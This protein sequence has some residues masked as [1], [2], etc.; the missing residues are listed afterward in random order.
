MTGW[1]KLHRSL[2]DHWIYNEKRKFS[3]LEAWIDILMTVN[4]EDKKVIVKGKLYD[5]KRGQSILS[6]DN[7]SKRWDWDKSST[8]RFFILLQND[9]MIDVISDNITTHLTV[10]NYETYQGERNADETQMKHKR[11]SNENQTTPTKEGKENK[12]KKESK[13]NAEIPNFESVLIYISNFLQENNKQM[14]DRLKMSLKAKYD[15]W[16]EN[17]WKD[18]HG[19]K[20]TNWKTK[21]KNSLDFMSAY[22][23][24]FESNKPI[25][26]DP[27]IESFYNS[28]LAMIK[29]GER[30]H[31]E[32][33][34][35]VKQNKYDSKYLLTE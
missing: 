5:V 19:N 22:K 34:E 25:F 3:K 12:E 2:N 7:W 13:N 16:I 33:N 17:D 8:R 35:V 32:H 21:F 24:L 26:A 23:D 10:C 15:S 18:G 27:K 4:Y 11:N 31:K 14:N 9:S 20:I 30:T 29:R 6:L 1:I 28:S